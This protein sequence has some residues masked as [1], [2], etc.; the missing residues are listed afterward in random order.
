MLLK[1]DSLRQPV[2]LAHGMK[3]LPHLMRVFA[4]WPYREIPK[5][6]NPDA[7][8]NVLHQ[9]GRYEVEA[10]WL[11]GRLRFDGPAEVAQG[12]ATHVARAW[13][14]QRRDLL[15][16]EAAA[17]LFGNQAVVFVGG[18]S[19]GKSLL[20]ASLA[21]GGNTVL[22]D[23]ILPVWPDGQQGVGLGMAPRLK[24][25]LPVELRDPLRGLVRD[26]LDSGNDAVGYLRAEDGM[27]ARFGETARIRA[28]VML[29]RSVSQPAAFAQASSG[30]LIKRLLLNS[31]GDSM[32]AEAL[33]QRV[34]KLANDAPCY[35]LAWSDPQEAASALRARFAAWR[36]PDTEVEEQRPVAHQPKARRRW[37]G[38][39]DP[40]GRQ[41]RHRQG[42][43]ERLVDADLF[44]VG[45][46]GQTIYH[47]NGLGAGL[48]RLL[49][50]THGLEDIVTVLKEAYPDVDPAAVEGDVRTLV[51]DL[52]E[53]GLLVEKVS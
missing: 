48:W 19:S 53:R 46:G 15:W 1:F 26:R 51:S 29:E 40:S 33:L 31:F 37:T 25:P 18:P 20:A 23:S 41:F 11:N 5:I 17:V 39:R 10:P 42:L 21:V 35:R 16:L 49:D 13:F 14:Q 38:P 30:K 34:E 6:G 43:T 8:I 45:P 3:V 24:L 47:L 22:A 28:F 52:C 32:N 36:T 4:R 50:G 44:L 12:L 7:I 27:I 2:Q 9:D